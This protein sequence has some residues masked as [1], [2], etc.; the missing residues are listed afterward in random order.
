MPITLGLLTV[1]STTLLTRQDPLVD[2]QYGYAKPV[3]KEA[4]RLAL[5]D[6][7]L[8]TIMPPVVAIDDL[9]G[10]MD[11]R[12]MLTDASKQLK[13]IAGMDRLVS[14]SFDN[15]S[16][17]D[18]MSWL[19]KQD[20]NF[21]V[22]IDTLPKKQLTLNLK[23]VP[24]HEALQTLA[25]VLDGHWEVKGSTAIFRSGAS[26][27]NRFILATMPRIEGTL[28]PLSGKGLNFKIESDFPG[29][30]AP[31]GMGYN[32]FSR[33]HESQPSK[34]IIEAMKS[35]TKEQKALQKKQGFLY[36]KDLTDVQKKALVIPVSSQKGLTFTYIINGEK[37]IIKSD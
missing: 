36:I 21:I 9:A 12:A 15:T 33:T 7:P 1:L 27:S 13:T 30:L 2:V 10:V 37:L 11:S 14:L 22:N 17:V 23:N 16:S 25:D 35:L 3:Q 32:N 34:T 28:S 19:V 20:V 4:P 18:V 24:I 31:L 8:A 26:I 6:V 5:Q 29:G